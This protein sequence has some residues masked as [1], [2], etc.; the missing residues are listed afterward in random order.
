MFSAFR[1]GE[2]YKDH[3]ASGVYECAKCG[4]ELFSRCGAVSEGTVIDLKCHFAAPPNMRTSPPGQHSRTLFIRTPSQK[5]KRRK[6][7]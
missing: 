2:K 7:H 5:L 4:Y 6:E 1:K 3:F